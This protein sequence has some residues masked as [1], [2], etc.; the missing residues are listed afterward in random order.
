MR[1]MARLKVAGGMLAVLVLAGVF[2]TVVANRPPCNEGECR[3]VTAVAESKSSFFVTFSVTSREQSLLEAEDGIFKGFFER[4][5][6]V[7]KGEVVVILI[8]ATPLPNHPVPFLRNVQCKVVDR[9]VPMAP[10]SIPTYPESTPASV[11]CR[12][13]V[14]W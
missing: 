2:F 9:G 7:Q 1:I 12:Y 11:A 4:D 8:V 5:V 13:V 10:G 14:T 3:I 6:I